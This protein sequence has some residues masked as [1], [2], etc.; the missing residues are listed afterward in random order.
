MREGEDR[1]RDRE[2]LVD[3][4]AVLLLRFVWLSKMTTYIGVFEMYGF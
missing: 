4:A 2:S 3:D 1:E